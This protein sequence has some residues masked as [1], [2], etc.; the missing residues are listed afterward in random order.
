MDTQS[1]TQ[2]RPGHHYPWEWRPFQRNTQVPAYTYRARNAMLVKALRSEEF[3]QEYGTLQRV[4]HAA[5]TLLPTVKG[6]CCLGV[7]CHVAAMSGEV[8]VLT[9]FNPYDTVTD[10]T[11]INEDGTQDSASGT[12]PF[13]VWQWFGWEGTNPD[14]WVLLDDGSDD[15][16]E[17]LRTATRLNDH[18]KRPFSFIAD[19]FER[20][21]VTYTTDPDPSGESTS[22]GPTDSRPVLEGCTCNYCRQAR[23]ANEAEQQARGISEPVSE[24]VAPDSE[25]VS[26]VTPDS[27]ETDSDL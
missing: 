5:A 6:V 13:G 14:L 17:D 8:R 22:D 9:A 21:Y 15:G 20:T 23:A 27:Y 2:A 19:A 24:V 4:T 11:T 7:A 26:E 18:D 12:P 16:R 1:T 10:F 25:P 3:T